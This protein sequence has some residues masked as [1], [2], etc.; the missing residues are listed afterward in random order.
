MTSTEPTQI[1]HAF[2]AAVAASDI[3]ALVDTLAPDVV[4]HSP[5][6][7]TPFEGPE[8]VGDLYRSLFEALEDVRITDELERGDTHVFFWEAR[9]EGRFVAGAD[10][11]RYGA[12]GKVRD[13]TV[14]GR[15]LTGVAGF[16]SAAGYH[17]ARRRRGPLVARILRITSLPL[18]PMFSLVDAL[19]RWLIRGRRS[20]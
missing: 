13:V 18:A 15:P 1:G 19:V 5:I 11:V 2:T 14:M 10:R 3:D 4:L 8:V 17:F 16:L 6:T 9:L 12:D 20:A 7:S